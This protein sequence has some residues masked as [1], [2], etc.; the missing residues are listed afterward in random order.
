MTPA[1]AAL[2]VTDTVDQ[3]ELAHTRGHH[4]IRLRGDAVMVSEDG[5][6]TIDCIKNAGS[7]DEMRDAT[8]GLLRRIVTNCRN[9]ALEERVDAAI[10]ESSDL[11]GLARRVRYAAAT[12]FDET[13]VGR[14]RSQIAALVSVVKGH[15]RPVDG[16]AERAD[17]PRVTEE[18][19][20]VPNRR[21]PPAG[22]VW[23]RKKRRLPPRR[24]VIALVAIIALV[25]LAWVAPAAWSELNRGWHTLLDPVDSSMDD[26]INPVSPPP[27]VPEAAPEAGVP[28][29]VDTGLPANAGPITQVA[30]SFANGPCEPGRSCTVRVDVGLDPAAN[31]GAVTWNLTVYDR[32]TGVTLPGRAIT[33]PVPAGSPEAYG[34]GSVDLPPGSALAVAAATTV[35]AEAAS[36]PVYVPTENAAC[37]PGGSRDGG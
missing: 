4:P 29:P 36:E 8:A 1:Q 5:Q 18:R 33:L 31:I 13:E 30:A 12:E 28:G 26:R 35:P 37:V 10:A 14:K 17:V 7:W 34:I 23:H 9:E 22:T 6:L 20:F 32:C 11:G 15:A 24:T 2:L 16:T 3:L 27:P 25:G 21:R 19:T